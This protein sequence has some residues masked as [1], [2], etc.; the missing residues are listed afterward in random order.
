M[1]LPR[2][3]ISHVQNVTGTWWWLSLRFGCESRSKLQ[4]DI[5]VAWENKC[6]FHLLSSNCLPGSNLCALGLSCWYPVAV[7][8][9]ERGE[10]GL[11][12]ICVSFQI[13][14]WTR[15]IVSSVVTS[16]MISLTFVKGLLGALHW[17][18]GHQ[19]EER[20]VPGRRCTNYCQTIWWICSNTWISTQ[21]RSWLRVEWGWSGEAIR[22]LEIGQR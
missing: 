16:F 10:Q 12:M 2:A 6:R 17:C 22:D 7:V 20:L 4:N 11:V 13:K 3:E 5:L 9:K 14:K 19:V 1:C 21:A 18:W 8:S 15:R